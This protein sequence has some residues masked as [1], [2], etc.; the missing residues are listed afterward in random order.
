[1]YTVLLQFLNQVI[2]SCFTVLYK[3]NIISHS[4]TYIY[5]KIYMYMCYDM[6]T[7]VDLSQY[8]IKLLTSS[9]MTDIN[10]PLIA[11]CKAIVTL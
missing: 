10:F 6:F 11:E 9:P 8:N 7:F 3:T 2:L 4:Y 5:Y 1:M